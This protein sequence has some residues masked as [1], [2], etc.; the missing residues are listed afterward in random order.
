MESSGERSPE[1]VQTDSYGPGQSIRIACTA[2]NAAWRCLRAQSMTLFPL[3]RNGFVH[4]LNHLTVFRFRSLSLSLPLPLPLRFSLSCLVSHSCSLLFLLTYYHFTLFTFCS[5]FY[6]TRSLILLPFASLFIIFCV[7][8]CLSLSL[9]HS[10]SFCS[11]LLGHRLSW[12][13][14]QRAALKQSSRPDSGLLI[15]SESNIEP[16]ETGEVRFGVHE[17][18]YTMIWIAFPPPPLFQQVLRDFLLIDD[19]RNRERT[20]KDFAK[21]TAWNS[22][23]KTFLCL[24]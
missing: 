22:W 6:F 15:H 4:S 14:C 23:A 18:S 1:V 13:L 12:N 24:A 5:I 21:Q 7:C 19:R 17:R 20:L 10:L 8:L 9:S 2:H 11:T 16:S 3:N